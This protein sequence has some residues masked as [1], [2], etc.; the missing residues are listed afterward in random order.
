M[1][2]VCK[3]VTVLPDTLT[4]IYCMYIMCWVSSLGLGSNFPGELK[5]YGK[6]ETKETNMI[7]R[8]I[9]GIAQRVVEVHTKDS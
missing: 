6:K 7:Q 3:A 5:L 2:F 8:N 4:I 9:T 1:S